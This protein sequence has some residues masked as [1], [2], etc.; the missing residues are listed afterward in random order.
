MGPLASSQPSGHLCVDLALGLSYIQLG[1]R[2]PQRT[3]P[4]PYLPIG[5]LHLGLQLTE[6]GPPA[7]SGA[8]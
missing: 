5:S 4:A 7:G 1:Y 8:G 6:E 3:V 2:L